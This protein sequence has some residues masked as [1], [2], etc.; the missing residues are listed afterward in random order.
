MCGIW[1]YFNNNS[2]TSNEMTS[3][4]LK[5]RSMVKKIRHR[6]PDWSG[7]FQACT[8]PSSRFRGKS[9][10]GRHSGAP[11]FRSY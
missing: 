5:F 4:V 8:S 11:A 10:F 3:K 6:G 7:S 1:A 9:H 2:I